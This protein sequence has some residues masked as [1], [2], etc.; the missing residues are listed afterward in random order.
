MRA[1]TSHSVNQ[2]DPYVQNNQSDCPGGQQI[3]AYNRRSGTNGWPLCRHRSGMRALMQR[4]ARGRL[5]APLPSVGLRRGGRALTGQ[6]PCAVNAAGALGI[7]GRYASLTRL[8]RSR[9]PGVARTV[10]SAS[11]DD[12]GV[13]APDITQELLDALR[14]SGREAHTTLF[15]GAGASTSSGLPDW[16]A[17]VTRLLV[18]S[19]AVKDEAAARLLLGRQDPLMV[20]EAARAAHGRHWNRRLRRALYEG[21]ESIEASPLH[22]AATRH[23]LSGDP[24]DT[25]IATLNF[26]DLLESSIRDSLGSDDVASRTS[27]DVPD[28][29]HVIHHLHGLV[30]ASD[31]R[32]CIL[33]FSEFLDLIGDA[34]AW[35]REFLRAALERG[36]ILIAGTSY[37]DP[38]IR[39]WLH[40]AL[41][42]APERHAA[43]VLLAREGFHVTKQEFEEMRTALTAQWESVRV[44]AVL[45]EDFS[46]A[47]Q[48]IRELRH[49]DDEGYIAPRDRSNT[50]W[51]YHAEHFSEL[52]GT[53]S[54]Q[55]AEDA[56]L[57]A[58]ELDAA[59]LNVSLW[60]ANGDGDVVR[61]ASQDRVYRD[62]GALRS[63]PTGFDS[64]W[65]AGRA[66]SADTILFQDLEPGS[67]RRWRSV[68]AAPIPVPH[69]E[70]PEITSAVLTV[71]LP[72]AAEHYSSSRML[73][74]P[75][76]AE[77]GDRWS[78]T[79][80]S[81]FR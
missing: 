23:L 81:A 32:D 46:D 56:A 76:I 16:D 28:A 58:E 80:G 11:W 21:V 67:T 7:R 9:R 3:P 30:T 12:R 44:R 59:E 47:A 34:T 78:V 29:E 74:G 31:V 13:G 22:L 40:A 70:L 38:D 5:S 51:E 14:D 54:S 79:L 6:R 42:E 33:T 24:G 36:A 57:I 8:Y 43:I 64:A 20:A 63:A 39:L 73:W 15:L 52:Q 71:G 55:L 37:R 77:C 75:V 61:W 2:S 65:V 1:P 18:S 53:F 62:L 60:L 19:N 10:P 69:P 4:A 26:D 49:L 66:V 25:T 72:Q 48:V 50:I 68:L 35:Q 45:M 17:L 41:K 27:A